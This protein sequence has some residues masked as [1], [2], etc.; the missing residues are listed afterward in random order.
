MI[1]QV[2]GLS[3]CRYY[4][5]RELRERDVRDWMM[6]LRTEYVANA[7]DIVTDAWNKLGQ[8]KE[9]L[10]VCFLGDWLVARQA[11]DVTVGSSVTLFQRMKIY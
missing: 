11:N 6:H 8:E 3:E 5:R 7:I 2:I 10:P 1:G 4:V 9:A